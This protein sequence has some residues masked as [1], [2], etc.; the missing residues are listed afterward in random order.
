MISDLTEN[1]QVLEVIRTPDGGGGFAESWEVTSSHWAEIIW[2][3]SKIDNTGFLRR[4][5]KRAIIKV[6]REVQISSANRVM[7]NGDIYRL[8]SVRPETDN[9]KYSILNIEEVAS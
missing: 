1:I 8:T 2:R 5:L 9:R 4:I 6:R 7:V 3:T